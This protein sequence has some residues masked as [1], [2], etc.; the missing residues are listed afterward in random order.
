ME[1]TRDKAF[2]PT[3]VKVTP[4]DVERVLGQ[5]TLRPDRSEEFRLVY[6]FKIVS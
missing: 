4:I 3:K 5:S 1:E 6:L 2:S